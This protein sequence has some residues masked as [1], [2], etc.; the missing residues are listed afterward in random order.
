[1]SADKVRDKDLYLNCPNCHKQYDVYETARIVPCCNKPLCHQC[2]HLIEKTVKDTKYRC[3][4]C[5]KE[6]Q[7]PNVGFPLDKDIAEMLEKSIEVINIE[8]SAAMIEFKKLLRDLEFESNNGRDVIIN[9]FREERSLLQLEYEERIQKIDKFHE[10]LLKQLDEKEQEQLRFFTEKNESFL[11]AKQ[12]IEQANILVQEY[13]EYLNQMQLD[14]N[15]LT[16]LNERLESL[17]NELEKERTKV[18]KEIFGDKLIRFQS[19]ELPSEN[20]LGF[21]YFEFVDSFKSVR[22]SFK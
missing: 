18:K 4:L 9:Y 10:E 13:K 5:E 6:E 17:Q 16:S 14:Q 2:I 12:K 19:E 21:F 8:E 22:F 11:N 7:L 20:S 15:E 3:V 1:M